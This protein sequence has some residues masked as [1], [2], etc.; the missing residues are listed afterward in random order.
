LSFTRPT[1][2][3]SIRPRGPPPK[4]SA[5]RPTRILTNPDAIALQDEIDRLEA[6]LDAARESVA[7][8][9]KW[10]TTLSN[11]SVVDIPPVYTGLSS[12]RQLAKENVELVKENIELSNELATALDAAEKAAKEADDARAALR[13]TEELMKAQ[14]RVDQLREVIARLKTTHE[15]KLKTQQA[16]STNLETKHIVAQAKLAEEIEKNTKILNELE[17]YRAAMSADLARI[18]EERNT[19][20][21]VLRKLHEEKEQLRREADARVEALRQAAQEEIDK[22][23]QALENLHRKGTDIMDHIRRETEAKTARLQEALATAEANRVRD[24]REAH[25]READAWGAL[26]QSVKQMTLGRQG[27]VDRAKK[28]RQLRHKVQDAVLKS[29]RTGGGIQQP[30]LQ[31]PPITLDPPPR[32]A[33]LPFPPKPAP[34]PIRKARIMPRRRTG[35]DGGDPPILLPYVS[36]DDEEG[37]SVV[38]PPPVIRGV[39]IDRG[40]VGQA[41]RAREEAVD[42]IAKRV[43]MKNV[44]QSAP[45]ISKPPTG[46]N[47]LPPR[48]GGKFGHSR[49]RIHHDGRHGRHA[50][51]SRSVLKPPPRDGRRRRRDP[52]ARSVRFDHRVVCSTNGDSRSSSI[53][54]LS[55]LGRYKVRRDLTPAPPTHRRRY[56]SSS[57]EGTPVRDIRLLPGGE[58]VRQR[59]R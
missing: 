59:V 42:S 25:Q 53:R 47:V 15:D 46:R 13:V 5:A 33:S 28:A 6:E 24:I 29:Q 57:R 37:G 32:P 3:V 4:L 20:Q 19:E 40:G 50:K 41:K 35:P 43:A 7:T 21:A 31:V 9:G 16:T 30:P 22:R 12:P 45:D 17:A 11:P 44:S 58:L 55:S 49:H 1:Q 56:S 8:H 48:A 39:P 26:G 18:N 14:D 23:N 27:S 52:S 10:L 38:P 54:S 34:K 2:D 51:R 36:D